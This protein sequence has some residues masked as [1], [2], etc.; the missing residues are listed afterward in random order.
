VIVDFAPDYTALM[1]PSQAIIPQTRGKKLVVY[2]NG[3]A[4]FADVTTGVR[5]S[6]NIQILSGINAGDTIVISGLMSVKPN[7][8]ISVKKVIN[9]VQSVNDFKK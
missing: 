7:G 9:P 2:K 3:I 6:A 5:D 1:V 8:K 4:T